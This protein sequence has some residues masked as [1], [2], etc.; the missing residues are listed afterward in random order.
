MATAPRSPPCPPRGLGRAAGGGA[1]SHA[2]VLRAAEQ[3]T[4]VRPHWGN[5]IPN[6]SAR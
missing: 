3:P 4:A 2:L 5:P 1:A 6:G